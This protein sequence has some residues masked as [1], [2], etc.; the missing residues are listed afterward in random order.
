MKN[1]SMLTVINTVKSVGSGLLRGY[2]LTELAFWFPFLEIYNKIKILLFQK[3]I[4]PYKQ[5]GYLHSVYADNS[6]ACLQVT[7]K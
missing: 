7:V 5:T 1:S 6:T 3:H 2:E 4:S